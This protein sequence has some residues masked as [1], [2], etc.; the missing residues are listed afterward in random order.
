MN[1][2]LGPLFTF[3]FQFYLLILGLLRIELLLFFFSNLFIELSQS[4]VV[5]I[6]DNNN[7]N[8]N[9][10]NNSDNDYSDNNNINEKYCYYY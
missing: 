9:N 3:F 4:H 8:N 2:F 7:N 5:K 1:V 6:D 10:N